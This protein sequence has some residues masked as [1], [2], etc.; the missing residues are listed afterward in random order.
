[1]I[2]DYD[3]QLRAVIKALREVVAPAI[4]TGERLAI[5]QL[6]LALATLAMLASRLPLERRRVRQ[7]LRNAL[8]LAAAL[9][10]AAGPAAAGLTA[11]MQTA[12]AAH[13]DVDCATVDLDQIRTVLLSAVCTVIE[14]PVD[15]ATAQQLA[16]VVVAASK[17]TIDLHRAWC[18][19][20]G[21]E[22]NPATLIAL[23]S[24]LK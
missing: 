5:E 24:I 7:E 8:A 20:A 22:A 21:F 1:M 17:P 12:R 14:T 2:P 11:P 13:A 16:R 23:E 15:E 19:S 4:D 18:A 6:Q 10:A 9:Q 3:L